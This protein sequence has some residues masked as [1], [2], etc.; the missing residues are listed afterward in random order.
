M[1]TGDDAKSVSLKFLSLFD[2][3]TLPFFVTGTETIL[4]IL[5]TPPMHVEP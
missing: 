2:V 4:T 5:T 3:V 1:P